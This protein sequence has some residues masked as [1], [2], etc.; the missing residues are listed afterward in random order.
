[1]GGR[2][3]PTARGLQRGRPISKARLR[4]MI[5]EATVDAYGESEQ[6]GGFYTM[7][8]DHLAVPFETT[9]LGVPVT[10]RGVDLT[11]NPRP[12]TPVAGTGR[13]RVDR[14]LPL[15]GW[16]RLTPVTSGE[17]GATAGVLPLARS[18][19]S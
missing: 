6:L 1:M 9:L 19:P 7:I 18:P 16:P 4:E 8:D 5:D 15:L 3:K 17:R 13:R 2:T 11:S 14:G 10:V 12:R